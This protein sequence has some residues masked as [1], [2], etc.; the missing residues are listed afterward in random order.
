MHAS[1]GTVTDRGT[2]HPGPGLIGA[3]PALDRTGSAI[4]HV[5]P[6]CADRARIVEVGVRPVRGSRAGA[7]QPPAKLW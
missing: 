4:A 5:D 2:S 6:R 1:P 3:G 7:S